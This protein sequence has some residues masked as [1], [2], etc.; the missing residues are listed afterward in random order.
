MS[1]HSMG[2]HTHLCVSSQRISHSNILLL[3]PPLVNCRVTSVERCYLP[4]FVES[5]RL[6]LIESKRLGLICISFPV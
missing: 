1:V 6:G 5:K 3:A 4:L 2:T